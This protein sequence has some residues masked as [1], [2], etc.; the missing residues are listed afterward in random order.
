MTMSFGAH[1]LITIVRLLEAELAIWMTT[2]IP[3]LEIFVDHAGAKVLYF[4]CESLCWRDC[5]T[6]VIDL[7]L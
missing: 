3:C 1:A 6:Y 2:E 7:L 4:N 5:V